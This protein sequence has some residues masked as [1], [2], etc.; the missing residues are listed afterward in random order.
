MSERSFSR[1][2]PLLAVLAALLPMQSARADASRN[3]AL[4]Y[5]RGLALLSPEL[6]EAIKAVDF[7]DLI[8]DPDWSPNGTTREALESSDAQS[9]IHEF[10]KA[11]AL[12]E[13]DFGADPED[14]IELLLPHLGGLRTGAKLL[15]LDGRT[16]L[17]D[18]DS[19]AASARFA[20]VYELAAHTAEDNFLVNSLVSVSIT[21]MCGN[22]LMHDSVLHRLGAQGRKTVGL[23]TWRFEEQDPFHL[24]RAIAS[25]GD[26]MT[27]WLR[28]RFAAPVTEAQLKAMME[29]WFDSTEG[30]EALLAIVN[31]TEALDAALVR[32]QLWYTQTAAD[33]NKPDA[34]ERLEKMK[35][36]FRSTTREH[37]YGLLT[38]LFVPGVTLAKKNEL[39][40][41]DSLDRAR[42]MLAN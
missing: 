38:E 5:W 30:T 31:D 16:K 13:C 27:V 20:A 21:T 34:M 9:V 42:A 28:D 25:D 11:G 23:A 10:L 32:M 33:W 24:Q 15:L 6:E 39:R 12:P 36:E 37:P 4:R 17:V 40:G 41:I 19:Q 14:G 18:G 29:E 7:D 2:L 35:T 22:V 8:G 1:F 26:L 3:A